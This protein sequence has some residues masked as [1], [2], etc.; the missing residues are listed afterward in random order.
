MTLGKVY[1]C[2]D[3]SRTFR[4]DEVEVK[5]QKC[6]SCESTNT[7]PRQAKPLPSWLMSRLTSESG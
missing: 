1:E 5:E 7:A 4:V 2:K 3:C 6:P